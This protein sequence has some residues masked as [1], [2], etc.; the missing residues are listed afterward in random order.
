MSMNPP[1]LR[2]WKRGKHQIGIFMRTPSGV[3]LEIVNNAACAEEVNLV[4]CLFIGPEALSDEFKMQL[5]AEVSR[6][7][8]VSPDKEST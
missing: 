3:V 5:V 2:D 6:F 1:K 8:A 4:R 7:A